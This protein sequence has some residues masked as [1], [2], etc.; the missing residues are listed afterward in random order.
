LIRIKEVFRLFL[1]PVRHDMK[2]GAAM[3]TTSFSCLML[4]ITVVVVSAQADDRPAFNNLRYEEV[5][6]AYRMVEPISLLDAMTDIPLHENT[7]T[8]LRLGGQVR[9]RGEAWENFGFAVD[10][11]D[12]FLLLRLRAHADLHLGEAVRIFVEGKSAT[13]TDRDLPGGR[14]T[15][16]V[17]ELD[18]QNAFVDLAHD[19]AGWRATL[20]LGRQELSY[21]AQRLVSPLDWSNTRRTWDGARIITRREDWRVDAFATRPVAIEQY[22]LNEPDDDQAFYG[23]YAAYAPTGGKQGVDLYW[24][25][26]DR[27]ELPGGDEE[28]ATVGARGYTVCPLTGVDVEG[29]AGWQYGDAGS[30]DI[31]AWFAAVTAGYTWSGLAIKPRAAIGYDMAS[32]DDDPGD[33]TAGT[34]N[35][36]FPLGHAYL[37]YLD[38]LGRQNITDF[39]QSVSW[40]PVPGAV[41]IKIDHHVFHRA[42]TADAAYNVGGGVLREGDAGTSSDLG[43]E[44]NLTL[45]WKRDR[46]TM[47]TAGYGRFWTGTFI[48]QSGPSEDIDFFHAAAQFTF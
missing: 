44:L 40:W 14:R 13:A 6:A 18:L 9:V 20:R 36:L 23:V 15:L 8:Y 3:K 2:R 1:Y 32:G 26:L 24:L 21:G 17:D 47:L 31:E 35:Q 43:R 48:E 45:T 22:S 5:G 29:E 42:E 27:D 11:D 37:G 10:E 25:R 33:G 12:A 46:H 34:F 38:V 41:Q 19:L 30:R 28:R 4:I 7:A 16:D 39:H